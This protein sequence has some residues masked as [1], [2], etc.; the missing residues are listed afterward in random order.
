MV[1]AATGGAG[2]C[3]TTDGL[4]RWPGDG[5]GFRAAT[6]A[7]G[8]LDARRVVGRVDGAAMV[9]GAAAGGVARGADLPPITGVLRAVGDGA[10]P[11]VGVL[12]AGA[13]AARRF[14]GGGA[15]GEP[16]SKARVR[17][18]SWL[19]TTDASRRTSA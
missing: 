6:F 16:G 8:V 3:T 9:G 5:A 19:S 17:S 7:A 12:A 1:T 11:R 13:R 4:L 10:G 18:I 14:A 15:C 2:S